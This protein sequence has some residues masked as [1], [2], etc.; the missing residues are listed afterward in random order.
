MKNIEDNK[1]KRSNMGQRK[2]Y[3]NSLNFQLEIIAKSFKKLTTDFFKEDVNQNIT[4]E[5]YVILDTLICYPHMDLNIMSKSL[6][7]DK[8]ELAKKFI[9]IN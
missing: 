7:Q 6:Y 9:K 5:E 3:V 8:S 2:H 1:E 4:F